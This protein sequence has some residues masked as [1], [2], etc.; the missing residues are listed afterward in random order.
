MSIR[1]WKGLRIFCCRG[2]WSEGGRVMGGGNGMKE[3]VE[4]E[5]QGV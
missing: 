1:S 4:R 2:I 5:K 3:W